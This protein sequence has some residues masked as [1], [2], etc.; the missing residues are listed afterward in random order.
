MYYD[1]DALKTGLVLLAYGIGEKT[2][3]G[4]MYLPDASTAGCMTGS[5]LGGHWSDRTLARLKAANGG[6]SF[7]E[8]SHN[9]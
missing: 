8:V 6:T 2:T 5:M 4:F 9:L 3:P 1:Y 7:P